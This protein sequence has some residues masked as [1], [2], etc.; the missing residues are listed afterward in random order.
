[1]LRKIKCLFGFHK[2]S[3]VQ[4]MENDLIR[5][6]IHCNKKERMYNGDWIPYV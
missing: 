2:W 4:H 5:Y 3:K 1:M 6:C